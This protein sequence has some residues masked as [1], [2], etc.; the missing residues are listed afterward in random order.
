MLR[1]KSL[2]VYNIELKPGVV[3]LSH[4]KKK[5]RSEEHKIGSKKSESNDK[6]Q[7]QKTHISLSALCQLFLQ[8]FQKRSSPYIMTL[9]GS[10]S[11]LRKYLFWVKSPNRIY[12]TKNCMYSTPY[13]S[14]KVQWRNM[15]PTKSKYRKTSY[16]VKSKSRLWLTIYRKKRETICSNG[17]MSK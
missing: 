10:G 5:Q 2:I 16:E 15:L 6:E 12:M 17:M 11:T 9:F 13:S 3:T 8:K 1:N 4:I 7:Y 14:S